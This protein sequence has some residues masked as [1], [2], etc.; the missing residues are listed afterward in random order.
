MLSLYAILVL[1]LFVSTTFY[2]YQAVLSFLIVTWCISFRIQFMPTTSHSSLTSTD[3]LRLGLTY[4]FLEMSL[5]TCCI[6]LMLSLYSPFN[7]YKFGIY[8]Y[9]YIPLHIKL[10]LCFCVYTYI[11]HTLSS[12]KFRVDGDNFTFVDYVLN[13]YNTWFGI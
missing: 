2:S 8:A 10:L 6:I 9:W 3:I 5:I 11:T 13:N 7:L 12:Y 1:I 4:M